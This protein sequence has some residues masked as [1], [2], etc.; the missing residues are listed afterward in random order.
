MKEN[1]YI[2]LQDLAPVLPFLKNQLLIITDNDFNVFSDKTENEEINFSGGYKQLLF[3]VLKSLIN[4]KELFFEVEKE[5]FSKTDLIDFYEWYNSEDGDRV[6]PNEEF[7]GQAVD[8]W[9]TNVKG[10]TVYATV[11]N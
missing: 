1:R 2:V 10:Q 4:N 7:I 8:Y 5:K 11:I 6:F 3:T 9:E